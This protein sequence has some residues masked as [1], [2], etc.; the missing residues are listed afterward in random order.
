MKKARG[1][2]LIGPL[3]ETEIPEMIEVWKAS[4]LPYKPRGRD[5]LKNLKAQR[6]HDPELFLGAFL[7][8]KLV[9]VVLAS[10]DGRRAWINRLAVIPE[11][12]G[13]GAALALV[14]RAENI[15][16]SR[17]RRLFCVQIEEGN[18][19]SIRFFQHAGY[20]LEHEIHYYTKR[21]LKSY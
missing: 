9:S 15:M 11:A 3:T 6:N 7:G 14:R 8:T 18:D 20:R 16:R 5:S 1:K 17:G 12:R 19:E 13:L 10:D 21:E 2:L 4:G